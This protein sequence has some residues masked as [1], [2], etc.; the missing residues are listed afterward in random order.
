MTVPLQKLYFIGG[1]FH[2]YIGHEVPQ[3]SRSYLS[4]VPIAPAQPGESVLAVP[5]S[6]PKAQFRGVPTLSEESTVPG[7]Y[8]V[9]QGDNHRPQEAENRKG[10]GNPKE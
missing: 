1:F 6:P 7:A 8:C 5:R 2:H 9:T 10:M 4:H 3:F